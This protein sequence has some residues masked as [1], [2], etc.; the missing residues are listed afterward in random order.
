MSQLSSLANQMA[1]GNPEFPVAL[2]L[3]FLGIISLLIILILSLSGK[4]ER[5][6]WAMMFSLVLVLVFM[7]FMELPSWIKTRF[8]TLP[9]IEREKP[10]EV[11]Q[12]QPAE[13]IT[14]PSPAPEPVVPEKPA[15]APE[16]PAQPAPKP[17]P[18]PKP[19]AQPAPKPIV[20]EPV[21]PE[22]APQPKPQPKPPET[23]PPKTAPSGMHRMTIAQ[24]PQGTGSI[25]IEIKGPIL[26]TSK[27]RE[28]YAHLMIILD[29]KWALVIP[30]TR[31]K[32]QTK[33][34]EFGEQVLTAV[35][36][37]WEGIKAGF[38]NVPP[39]PH[40]V[41]IDV[42]LESPSA[43]KSKMIGAGNLENDYNGSVM[44]SEGQHSLMGFGA[45]NWMTQELERIR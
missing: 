6:S 21:K 42:S 28:P 37:F 10:P 45:K 34:N 26:E 41:L 36:Y 22:P 5:S 30:P 7:G 35:S 39:G 25:D 33:E 13:T 3:G 38:D 14:P 8:P 19:V 29:G 31:F 27:T 18:A 9:Q 16:K 11:A 32:E 43:H 17:E 15:P 4:E 24:S 23:P 12:V 1:P 2:Y 20:S 44:V 40:L